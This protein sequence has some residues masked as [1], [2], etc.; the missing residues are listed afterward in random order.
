MG[1]KTKID[2]CDSTWNPVVGCF[3]CCDYCYARKIAERFRERISEKDFYDLSSPM[4]KAGEK[5]NPVIVP[6]PYG[7]TPTFFRYKLDEIQKWKN[8]KN[9]FVCSMAD[10]FGGWVPVEWITEVFKSCENVPQH[11]YLFLTKNPY[12]YVSLFNDGKLPIHDNFWYGT[13]VDRF[14]CLIFNYSEFNTFISF[15]PLTEGAYEAFKQ[16]Y[17]FQPV[18]WFIIGAETGR[19]KGKIVP[20]KEWIDCIL[21]RAR[22]EGISVFMKD[23]LKNIYGDNLIKE[24]PDGLD[25]KSRR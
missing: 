25:N 24:Y 7:F 18:K 22:E 2:W 17:S 10:L 20:K 12:R 6:Y 16:T 8:P 13:T 15:E 3:N 23:S 19:R 21:K 14:G 5:G 1:I 4:L 9:I 11:N